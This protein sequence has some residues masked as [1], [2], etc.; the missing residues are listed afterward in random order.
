MPDPRP[1]V[2]GEAAIISLP[3]LVLGCP[4]MHRW[5]AVNLLWWLVLNM[6]SLLFV[7]VVLPGFE[8]GFIVCAHQ[9]R[10]FLI[11]YTETIFLVWVVILFHLAAL[12]LNTPFRLRG[13]RGM[14][15]APISTTLLGVRG[16]DL[17]NL[18][19]D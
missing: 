14:G 4:L 10:S 5:M 8:F 12:Q 15:L 16:R 2:G 7:S 19:S 11:Y 17:G 18:R 9:K 1:R 13:L 3:L 6:L